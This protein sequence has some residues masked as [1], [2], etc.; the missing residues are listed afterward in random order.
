MELLTV[1]VMVI[2][3]VWMILAGISLLRNDNDA[4]TRSAAFAAM[5]FAFVAV[6]RS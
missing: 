2:G 4:T 3:D 5:C 6:Q 1:G